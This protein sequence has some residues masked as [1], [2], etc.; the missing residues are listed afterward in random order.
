MVKNSLDGKD[1]YKEIKSQKLAADKN[2][3]WI[4]IETDYVINEG[5]AQAYFQVV[6]IKI[7][8][9]IFI[10]FLGP[11]LYRRSP[12]RSSFQREETKTF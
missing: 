11:F 3:E 12:Y 7:Y 10:T 4:R 6:I 8:I 2:K 1:S 5:D 9:D